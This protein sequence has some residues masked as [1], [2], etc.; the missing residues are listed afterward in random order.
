MHPPTCSR[1]RIQPSSC[2]KVQ[3]VQ[4]VVIGATNYPDGVNPALRR[5]G[6][7]DRE[8]F[9]PLPDLKVREKILGIMTKG[10]E[11]WG[12]DGK[13]EG[14]V[15][16]LMKLPGLRSTVVLTRRIG[17]EAALNAIRRRYPQILHASNDRLL[18]KSN[19]IGV[20]PTQ[21]HDFDQE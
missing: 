14:N 8:F 13:G 15:K 3:T 21:F 20:A 2:A 12:V 6:W 4:I 10:W 18:I 9:L 5:P 16:G 1:S 19:T 7:F 17:T 11:E